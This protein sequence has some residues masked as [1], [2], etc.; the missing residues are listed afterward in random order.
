MTFGMLAR[1][2]V[3]LAAAGLLAA[4]GN[5]PAATLAPTATATPLPTVTPTPD[6]AALHRPVSLPEHMAYIWWNWERGTDAT[7]KALHEFREVVLDFT[8]HN[9]PG[10]FSSSHGLY[11]MACS[12]WIADA[13]FYFGLQTDV[14]DPQESGG[15]GK[16]VIFS[17]WEERDLAFARSAPGGWTQSSGHEGDFIG[18]RLAYDW[19]AGD[20]RM[21]MAPAGLDEDGEWYAV[22][23]TDLSTSITTWAGSLKFPLLEGTTA[24]QSPCYSTLEIYGS[25]IRPVD[26]PEWHVSIAVPTG[27]GARA[28]WGDAGYSFFKGEIPNSDIQ[29]D[30]E[31]G[32]VHLRVGGSTERIGPAEVID[33]R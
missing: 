2:I 33:F 22:W 24:I 28:S 30:R 31:A 5:E 25:S 19:G 9:D 21:R 1:L 7:G 32:I 15:R 14:Y 13:G 26:I 29:Y 10:N 27:D 23:V 20:Y 18:V 8:L 3:V 12:A 4:C 6:P 16:G 11:M 17:R